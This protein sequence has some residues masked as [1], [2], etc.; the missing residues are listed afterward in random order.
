MFDKNELD[1]ELHQMFEESQQEKIL[2][3]QAFLQ[4][5]KILKKTDNIVFA[6]E[7]GNNVH[8]A[9]KIMLKEKVGCIL[10]TKENKLTGIFTEGDV[11]RKSILEKMDLSQ[12]KVEHFMSKD[13][14][15]LNMEDS[16]AFVLNAMVVGGFRHIPLVDDNNIPVSVVTVKDIIN[17]IVS[18][19]SEEILNLPPKPIHKSEEREGA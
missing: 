18:F 17:Y 6:I 15:S 13:P 8:D 4:P 5:I 10:V 7:E 3:S 12:T 11:T 16:I 14:L 19:F 9:L 2:N 1:D